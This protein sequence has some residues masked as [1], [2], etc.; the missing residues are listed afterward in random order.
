MNLVKH[1]H[2]VLKPFL[3]E[4]SKMISLAYSGGVDSHVL[5]NLLIEIIPNYPQH[6]FHAIHVNHRLSPN[7]DKWQ[8]YC[9]EFCRAHQINF[10]AV[11][12]NVKR[13]AGQSLEAVAREARYKAILE[14]TPDEGVVLLA[15]HQDDQLETLLLQLKRGAGPKGLS[16][17]AF[18][19]DSDRGIKLVRPLLDVSQQQINEYA[20]SNKLHWQEDE[21]NQNIAFERNFLRHQII[22][23]LTEQWPQFAQSVGRTARL[24]AEQQ[25]LL[26][27][28]SREKLEVLRDED[29]T[30]DVK[31]LLAYSQPWIYQLVR[32]WLSQ[33]AITMPSQAILQQLPNLLQAQDDAN[34]A[35]E[36]SGWQ[37]RRF[38]N[39][40]F[41]LPNRPRVKAKKYPLSV[42]NILTL[43]ELLGDIS[44]SVEHT[45]PI[46]NL[47]DKI[48]VHNFEVKFGGFSV[49]FKPQGENHSKPLK[50][51][52]KHWK[53]PPWQRE[54]AAQIY[55]QD[56]LLAVLL[57]DQFIVSHVDDQ[58][59]HNL[60]LTFQYTRQGI[61]GASAT[62]CR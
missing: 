53:I 29:N 33:Q 13:L 24:C 1:L 37:L 8:N 15:Q 19:S 56:K 30:L 55:Y 6:R 42:N 22:P 27:E 20:I 41:A 48:S 16:S 23:K 36:W 2:T 25:Q 4:P 28:V 38:Q 35:I 57:N 45:K 40:L 34:P 46:E 54:Q 61:C 62:I 12:V 11:N 52:F 49:K 50:Q 26:D 17:M 21:S 14:N 39:R 7:A 59:D 58:H 60:Q 44:V 10:A 5:L 51:W 18:C 3:A 9:E 31:G 47:S 32:L 43:P